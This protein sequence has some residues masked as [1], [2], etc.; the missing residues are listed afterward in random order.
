MSQ[1]D[2]TT[3][4]ELR[5]GPIGVYRMEQLVRETKEVSE[6]DQFPGPL[7]ENVSEETILYVLHRRGK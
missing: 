2:N 3:H 4:G 1:L 6:L 5:K 7:T